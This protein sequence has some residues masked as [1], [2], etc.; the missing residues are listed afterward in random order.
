M[1]VHWRNSDPIASMPANT[2]FSG[3]YQS[4][5][6]VG[7]ASRAERWTLLRR[8]TAGVRRVCSNRQ[9]ISHRP[10]TTKSLRHAEQGQGIEHENG[11][12]AA[13]LA[14]PAGIYRSGVF[15]TSRIDEQDQVC[16][17]DQVGKL[18]RELMR[19]QYLNV[20]APQLA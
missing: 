19:G 8:A 2:D 15:A 10:A 5:N 4:S 6:K 7:P 3:Q 13:R 14:K 20:V 16:A 11:A 1:H 17:A 12:R 18:R 9:K